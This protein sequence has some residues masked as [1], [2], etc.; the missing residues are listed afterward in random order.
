MRH[1]DKFYIG[2]RWVEPAEP[3]Q[4]DLINPAT[5]EVYAT[6]AMGSASDVDRAVAAARSAFPAFASSSKADRIALFRRII[7]A[8]KERE[9]DLSEAISRE[10]GAPRSVNV[11]T[12]SPLQ[13][14]EQTIDLIE[15]YPFEVVTKGTLIRRE[16][17]G[18]AGLITP[19]NWPVQSICGKLCSALAAGTPVVLKPSEY[20]SV[21][22]HLLAEILDAADVPAGVFNLVFGDGPTVG[23]AIS[24][25]PDID[26]VSFTG[27]TRAGV[28]VAIDAAPTVKRVVQELGGKSANIILPDA[29]LEE[30]ARWNV[31][32]GM[33]NSGQSCHSPSRVLVQ[34]KQ[35]QA[36]L[37]YML[38]EVGK[39]RVGD[40]QLPDT[41]LGPV[42]NRNQFERIQHLISLGIKE[43]AR[44]LCGGTSRPE[45]QSQG[46]FVKPTIFADVTPAMT[47]AQQ[48]IFGPVLSVMTY[49]TEEEAIE[50]ANG[51]PYGLGAY[52]FSSSPETARRV[53]NALRAGRVF[54]NGDN[55]DM[56]APMGGYKQS[57][58]GRQNG[59]FGL[60][61]YLE[62]KAM[63]GYSR[64]N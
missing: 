33:F 55:G 49:D 39:I 1:Y 25:H 11:H 32:R 42:I 48:E 56:R 47:I 35:L 40:P 9:A 58:N 63:F 34:R 5:E 60:E 26:M 14:L 30:A 43:G 2:G 45:G 16:S 36:V 21:S 12:K 13:I 17:I 7:N 27:S 59:T 19:W 23:H 24:T 54:L 8:F 46:Y 44:L 3:R 38:D 50:I 41:T 20:S 61:E 31:T 52:L 37:D 64:K 57:G 62:V 22:A 6:L 10:L 53:G 15:E 4:I 29:D 51:T 28:Q 18:V